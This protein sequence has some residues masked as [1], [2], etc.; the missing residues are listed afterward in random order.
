MW[1]IWT[2]K[3][4]SQRTEIV[5]YIAADDPGAAIALDERFRDAASR[6]IEFPESGRPGHIAGTREVFPHPHYRLVYEVDDGEIWILTL[7]HTARQWPGHSG[8]Q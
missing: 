6:L 3:A 4:V 2:D 1:V 5:D 8:S 7:V